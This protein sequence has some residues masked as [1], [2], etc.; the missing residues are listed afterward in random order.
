MKKLSFIIVVFIISTTSLKA[1][2]AVTTDGSSADPSAMLDVKSTEKGF[3]PP[4]MTKPEKLAIVNPANGLVVYDTDLES[5]YLYNGTDW[6]PL[7]TGSGSKW[8]QGGSNIFRNT[9][10][11]GI[12]TN[13]PAAL[14]HTSGIGTGQ[15]NVLF[16]GVF[17]TTPGPAP[18]EGPGTRMMWYPDKAA[19]RVGRALGTEWDGS[20]IGNTSFATGLFSTASGSLSFATGN[21]TLA[22]GSIST[23]LGQSTTASGDASIA[24]GSNTTAPSFAETVLGSFN[25]LYTPV[26]STSFDI[27]DRLFVIGNGTGSSSRKNAM[28]VKKSGNVGI[29]TSNPVALL[30]TQGTGTGQGNVL[31]TGEFKTTPG[32]SPLSGAGTR[33]M[34][35]PDK[36]AFRAGRVTGTEWDDA[37]IGST[38]FA[39]GVNSNASG[40]NSTAIGNSTIASGNSSTAM[41]QASEASGTQSTAMGFNTTASGIRSTAIGFSTT[42]SGDN[43]LSAGNGSNATGHTS[44]AM[45]NITT[46]SGDIST[47]MGRST[48]APSFVE[49]AIGSFNTTYTP[50]SAT[51]FNVSDRLF[52]IGN[53]ISST[54]PSDAMVVMK[55][56]DV[57]IGTSTPEEILE[58]ENSDDVRLRITSTNNATAAIDLVRSSTSNTDWRIQ[59]DGNLK[60]LSGSNIDASVTEEYSFGTG[61]FRPSDDNSKQLGS[62]ANR[63]I[64]VHAVNGTIQ[65]SDRRFKKDIETLSYGLDQVN[66]LQPVSYRWKDGNDKSVHVGLIAQDVQKIIP[67][68]VY[69][70]D[71]DRLGLNYSELVPVLIQAIRELSDKVD[72]LQEQNTEQAMLIQQ[73]SGTTASISTK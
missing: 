64:S 70:S 23:A 63:W 16:T 55:N 48:S 14:L 18:V 1:Q 49:T 42:A 6:E 65:T 43:S 73:L 50:A 38:S 66:Q 40:S 44:T 39:T 2:V 45:G 56:G 29:G 25:T 59:N 52:V 47:T 41:G 30:H 37:N 12:G 51:S 26:S 8:E 21:L 67:E 4:R 60:L 31:F 32:P 10:N 35:Y 62:S 72:D 27:N 5:L 53:G 46:A 24:M 9:G 19:F 58:L 13:N 57:G 20:N 11:V 22:S 33:M 36:A 54:T 61:I 17:K 15:G 28:V 68:A 71:P 34:W 69:S 7:A 3:L